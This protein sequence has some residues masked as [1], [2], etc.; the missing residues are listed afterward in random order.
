MIKYENEK[1]KLE[2][3]ISHVIWYI[4]IALLKKKINKL[5]NKFFIFVTIITPNNSPN[6][7]VQIYH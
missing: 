7:T 2:K 6:R 1:E 5:E 3:L 4:N